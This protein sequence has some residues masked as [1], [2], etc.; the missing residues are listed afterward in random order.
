MLVDVEPLEARRL[1]GP[2]LLIGSVAAVVGALV[3][4]AAWGMGAF[5]GPVPGEP[6]A[7]AE[8][9][10]GP[11]PVAAP[12]QAPAIPP[13]AGAAVRLTARDDV[14]IRISDPS[15]GSR[16]FE[17]TMARGQSIDV[18]PGRALVLRAGRAGAIEV[19]VGTEVLPPLGGPADVLEAQPL[20]AAALRAATAPRGGLVDSPPPSP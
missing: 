15:G 4:L 11:P 16:F 1:P 5:S 12:V 2:G 18:P 7:S 14:W 13:A 8:A 3:L 10:S 9:A 6:E 17:G 20:D 19:R